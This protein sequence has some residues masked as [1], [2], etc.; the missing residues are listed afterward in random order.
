MEG[1]LPIC[2]ACKKIRDDK[3]NW[4]HIE[5]YIR[6]RSD[7]DFTHTICPECAKELY[8]ELYKDKKP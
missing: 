1:L 8:P 4:N 7:A 5:T 2:A 3:N 6:D